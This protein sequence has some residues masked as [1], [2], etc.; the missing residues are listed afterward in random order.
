[1]ENV[2]A[3]L[4]GGDRQGAIKQFK[5][6]DVLPEIKER[7]G[8]DDDLIYTNIYEATLD[9]EQ[10]LDNDMELLTY[11]FYIAEVTDVTEGEIVY[12]EYFAIPIVEDDQM[13]NMFIEVWNTAYNILID[14]G[15]S[16]MRNY[17]NEQI[18][19]GVLTEDDADYMEEDVIRTYDL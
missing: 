17:L 15:K 10:G 1:M 18:S 11:K 6:V 19:N 16:A 12:K 2:E 5:V 14:D 4:N 8:W 9:P 3:R 13:D 7:N